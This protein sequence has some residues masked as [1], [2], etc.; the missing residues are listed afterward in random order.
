MH[1]VHPQMTFFNWS[2][3]G[4][5]YCDRGNLLWSDIKED[6]HGKERLAMT[7]QEVNCSPAS[8]VLLVAVNLHP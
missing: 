1:L 8:L 4:S 2:L 5:V 3:R 7:T 6:C